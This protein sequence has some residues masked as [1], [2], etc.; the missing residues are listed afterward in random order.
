MGSK[1][2]KAGTAGSA[3]RRLGSWIERFVS[4][5]LEQAPVPTPEIYRRWAG[6][7]AIGACL[8]QKVWLKPGHEPLYPNL[9]TLLVGP[10]ATGKSVSI[11][12]A[13][14]L[15]ATIPDFPFAPTSVTMAALVDALAQNKREYINDY[16][17]KGATFYNS[18]MVIPDDLQVLM[19]TYDLSLIA[20]LTTFYDVN[21]PYRERRRTGDLRIEIKRPQLS[22]LGGTT[23]SHLFGFIPEEAWSQG[24]TSRMILIYSDER[25]KENVR[26]N[27]VRL[28]Y[29]P[30][31]VNDLKSINSLIG[32][33]TVDEGATKAFEDWV[34]AGKP[35][36]PS[37]K[38]LEH[39]LGRRYPHL[40]K[41]CMVSSA[42]RGNSLVITVED[43][44]RAL[45]WLVE[46]EHAMPRIFQDGPKT[47]ESKIMD[48][49]HFY[50]KSIDIAGKGVRQTLIMN[51]LV[52]RVGTMAIKQ[53][54]EAMEVGGY[55]KRIGHDPKT[56]EP[57]WIALDRS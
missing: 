6:I 25:H 51:Y 27:G 35:P 42:D 47:V 19:S 41:L 37:H 48:E 49:V 55:V 29:P 34:E 54:W 14:G 52:Q 7:T 40:L 43:F 9:Y 28:D 4:Y 39:Y 44:N 53:F 30:D 1:N 38:R 22:I 26:F 32:E 45:G 21:H 31:L 17:G 10:P 12:L 56:K 11:G 8:E 15:L 33:F 3:R 13:R 20:G 50:I 24:F 18:M 46:A 5:A 36:V 2:T 16:T 57:I 23:P